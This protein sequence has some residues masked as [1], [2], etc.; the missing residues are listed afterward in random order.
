[1]PP[2]LSEDW[3]R[4]TADAVEND[5]AFARVAEDFE[6][7]VV[8]G[9]GADDTA[10]RFSDGEMDVLGDPAFVTWDFAMR[11]PASTWQ[12]LLSENPPPLHHDVIGTWLQSDLTIEGDLRLAL[13]HLRPLKRLLSVF[14]EVNAR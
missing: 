4:S 10:A 6:A 1:M 3:L 2:V 9:V 14:R 11:A 7:T 13:R 5:P 8:F 12:K